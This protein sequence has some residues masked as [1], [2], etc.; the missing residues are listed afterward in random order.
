MLAR[1]I[2][3][4]DA[5]LGAAGHQP[6]SLHKH[7]PA[8]IVLLNV[9]VSD[10]PMLRVPAFINHHTGSTLPIARCTR[11]MEGVP[12]VRGFSLSPTKARCLLDVHQ[13][14]ISP[15]W[16]CFRRLASLSGQMAQ[17]F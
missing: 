8:Q 7:T 17:P 10:G 4:P 1:R 13:M 14:P 12:D 2:D 9:S 16:A 5:T 3:T 15:P 6:V 11:V